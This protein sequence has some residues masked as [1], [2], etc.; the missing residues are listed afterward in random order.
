M[1]TMPSATNTAPLVLGGVVLGGVTGAVMAGLMVSSYA[2]PC[3]SEQRHESGPPTPVLVLVDNAWI[4]GTVRTCDVTRDSQ[5][6]SVVVSYGNATCV[7]TA[8]F[9]ANQ[10]RR[11]RRLVAL[12]RPRPG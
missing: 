9:D 8:R 1:G 7:T 5:T 10:M 3:E 12:L 11:D 4:C 2:A 6:S